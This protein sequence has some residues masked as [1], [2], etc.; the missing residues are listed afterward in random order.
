MKVILLTDISKVG[1]RYDIKEVNS[2][3]ALN[4]LIPK[5]L[6]IAATPEALKRI[7]K[8]KVQTEGEK[9]VQEELLVKNLEVLNGTTLTLK[10][11][12][13]EK[14]HLFAGLHRDEIAKE[15]LNQSRISV[16]PASIML[17][18]PIKETGTHIV[19]VK[20]G[21]KSAKFKLIIEAK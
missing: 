13:N 4:F 10:E 11:K 19:E 17:E 18:H 14:G 2:G 12:A 9:K 5:N 6:A 16:D 1:R 7:E 15:L 8:M 21:S 20:V 3:H